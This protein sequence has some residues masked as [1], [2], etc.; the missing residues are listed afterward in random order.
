MSLK[1]AD[2]SFAIRCGG[3]TSLRAIGDNTLYEPDYADLSAAS[4]FVSGTY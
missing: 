1:F 3:N 4:Y 2:Y